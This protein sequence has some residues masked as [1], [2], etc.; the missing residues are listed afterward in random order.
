[1]DSRLL[2]LRSNTVIEN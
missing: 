2:N 1:M